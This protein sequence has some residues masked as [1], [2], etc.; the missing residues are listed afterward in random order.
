M[1]GYEICE[2]GKYAYVYLSAV[3]EKLPRGCEKWCDKCKAWMIPVEAL[4]AAG[5]VA[6]RGGASVATIAPPGQMEADQP[7][8]ARTHAGT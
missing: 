1:Q 5:F 2:C 7:A 4:R 6:G 3:L 8:D